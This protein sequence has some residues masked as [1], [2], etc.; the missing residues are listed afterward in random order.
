M[1]AIV[2]TS[3]ECDRGDIETLSLEDKSMIAS[4]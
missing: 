2:N 4:A 1:I 3:I